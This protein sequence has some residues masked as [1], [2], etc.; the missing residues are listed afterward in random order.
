MPVLPD[1]V[2][3][4]RAVRRV[5]DTKPTVCDAQIGEHA[6]LGRGRKRLAFANFNFQGR[7][8]K[9]LIDSLCVDNA[10][11]R[12]FKDCFG[13]TPKPTP[14]TG[15][16]PNLH[17]TDRPFRVADRLKRNFVVVR[18]GRR[19]RF[20]RSAGFRRLRSRLFI[21]PSAAATPTAARPAAEKLHRLADHAHF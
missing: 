16:L 18:F 15:V 21:G 9:S 17:L 11:L 12:I 8:W 1:S 19:G 10:R 13:E 20:R 4:A 5:A 6:R 3:G 14:V 2:V 7:A